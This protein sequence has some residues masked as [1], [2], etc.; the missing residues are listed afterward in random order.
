MKIPRFFLT[1]SALGLAA[2]FS[3]LIAQAP[4]ASAA[5]VVP[6]A[7]WEDPAV[8]RIDKLPP[9]ATL[10]AFPAAEA[11]RTQPP[12]A[13][14]WRMS[15]NGEWSFFHVGHPRAVPAGFEQPG[16]DASGWGTLP[17]PSNWQMHG[18]G[19]PLFTNIIYPF[20]KNPPFVMGVPPG[21]F[22]NFPEER[23]NEVGLY[24]RSFTVPAD[25][26][27]RRVIIHFAGVNSALQLW[28]N[29]RS[30]GYSED[31]RT[32]AEFDLTPHLQPGENVL[33][34]Q[35]W[36]NCDGSYLEDQDMWRLSG[37]FRD[38]FLR[39]E[40][41]VELADLEL[42]ASLADGY[43]AGELAFHPTVKNHG[44]KSVEAT[45][46]LEVFDPS[47]VSLRTARLQL[48]VPAGRQA[49]GA[50]EIEPIANVR[51]WSAETPT[52]YTASVGIEVAGQPTAHYAL[53]VGFRTSEIKN[54][55]LLV[56]GQP[57]LIK[58]VNRHEIDP[59]T[60]HH[61][62]EA[63]M[64]RDLLLMK[65]Y[66][67]NAV[68]TSHYPNDTRFYELCDELG[69]Y[70]VDEANIETH[71]M[72][73]GPE[74]LAKN[75]VWEAA[76]LDRTINMLERDK[77]H[78]SVIIW[79]LGNEAGDGVNFV[80]A[81]RWLKQRDPSR[82]VMSEQAKQAAHTDLITPM[83][84]TIDKMRA[85][86][87][88][89]SKK[90]LADQR[91][92]IQCE[93]SHAMGNSCGNLAEYWE[94]IRSHRLL[95]GGFIWDWV[96]Q[97][98]LAHKQAADAVKDRSPLAQR[99]HLNGTLHRDEGLVIGNL[100]VDPAPPL[101]ALQ[102]FSVEA[103]VRG[104]L[105]DARNVIRKNEPVFTR[106]IAGQ[107]GSWSLGANM[108]LTDLVF[109]AR[110]DGQWHQVSM[111]LPE[112]WLSRFHRYEAGY[113]GSKMTL[114]ID[115]R[116]AASL[117]VGGTL[118]PSAAPLAL[119]RA[120]DES[121]RIFYGAIR[122]LKLR[123]GEKNLC[124][125]DFVAAAR[126][127]ATRPFFAY[128]GDFND[129]P[130]DSYASFDGLVTPDRQPSPQI[131]EVFKVQQNIHTA[132]LAATA[133]E[134]TLR[135]RNEFFFTTLEAFA[136]EWELTE[137]G[138][139]VATGPL[140]LP[141]I[142]PQAEGDTRIA[143]PAGLISKA[144]AEYH[145]RVLHRLRRDE[146][147]AAAGTIMAWDQLALALTPRATPQPN[148]ANAAPVLA[149]TEGVFTELTTDTARYRFDD[150]TGALVSLKSLDIELLASPLHLN[151]WRPPTNN[152][153]GGRLPLKLRPWRFAGREA[154]VT[155]RA[156]TA[157][158]GVATLRY[159][160][161]IPVGESTAEFV[162]RVH[163][164]GQ[165]EME[166]VFRPT[167]KDLPLLPRVGL[168]AALP[169]DF[170]HVAWF[171]KGPYENHIDRQA[172]SWVGDFR[173]VADE[174]FH[175]YQD[176]QESGHRTGVRHVS[177]T[178]TGGAGLKVEAMGASLLEF[179][180]Y[181]HLPGDIELARHPL[182]LPASD[183]VTIALD[184]AMMG[185]SGTNS[186]GALPLPQYQL[187]A[188]REYRFSFLFTPLVSEAALH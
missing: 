60:G 150:Q 94:L 63:S 44:A 65:R 50:L 46:T 124:D 164:S 4:A 161:A 183:V 30:V 108:L 3:A 14:P 11:A 45:A 122:S 6:L 24:R 83:Y 114:A 144:G 151:F 82:P 175:R 145:L 73:Y 66:N 140:A 77:N 156:F 59:Q 147:W 136:S 40:G 86:A 133:Q 159:T 110:I 125:L 62:S 38:V 155:A 9:R 169:R 16:F 184:H 130:T 87:E 81:S 22:S 52:L 171:G 10:T 99:T 102:T 107:A 137:N 95:Q 7:P 2:F 116:P 101:R 128:G 126:T 146:P 135:I 57:I 111:P 75:P 97:G 120:S 47:G 131:P 186:W 53:R 127:P 178:R 143:F 34:A 115:G 113:D 157:E 109:E 51:R 70:V 168:S 100:W 25:W 105:S 141:A 152:D 54:G 18:H 98:L 139:V 153:E 165:L 104:N 96:D 167:G 56:N 76:H 27:G 37:I 74:S 31:S 49:R 72:G 187:P 179:N 79:S 36:Q 1:C 185:L 68:R 174:F 103:D 42:R 26:A 80:A 5:S 142:A 20:A 17:V 166:V 170:R 58:G 91:P 93:Y 160:L 15:L 92:M 149:R 19:A 61:V 117:A 88:Q 180:A 39:S 154:R 89:E 84:D 23:R 55:Q 21:H 35:V 41:A 121:F 48:N 148:R 134:A 173:G 29:G 162:Y 33:A 132:L 118:A 176:P 90:P 71:G 12:A 32:P 119:F 64:R 138:R 172:G 112:D 163:G 106:P 8:F 123:A 69:L 181:P 182:D 43:R 78:P 28:V 129:R 67:I 85:F 188:D 158:S 177:F 13:S